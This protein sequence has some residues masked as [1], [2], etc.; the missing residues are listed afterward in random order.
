MSE[1]G[2]PELVHLNIDGLRF[3]VETWTASKGRL[4]LSLF[5]YVSKHM[6]VI[7]IFLTWMYASGGKSSRVLI[8]CL[9][10]RGSTA[11]S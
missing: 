10:F 3:A 2:D 8:P 1:T 6:M 5:E 7:S 4:D 9:G 11:G